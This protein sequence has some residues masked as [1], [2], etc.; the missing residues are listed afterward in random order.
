M[1]EEYV[2]EFGGGG[3]Q[4]RVVDS[5]GRLCF[6]HSNKTVALGVADFLNNPA[7]PYIDGMQAWIEKHAPDRSHRDS[8]E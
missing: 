5:E 7:T 3:I 8:K 4:H 2:V 1:N 6:T